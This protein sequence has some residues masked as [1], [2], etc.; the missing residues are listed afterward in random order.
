MLQRAR[1]KHNQQPSNIAKSPSGARSVA[2]A[3]TGASGSMWPSAMPQMMISGMPAASVMFA[4]GQEE[5]TQA[6]TPMIAAY[7]HRTEGV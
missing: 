2:S 4:K 1:G 3:L 7:R 5:T 6:G